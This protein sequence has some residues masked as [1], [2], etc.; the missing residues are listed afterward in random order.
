[1]ENA[2]IYSQRLI[3]IKLFYCDADIVADLIIPTGNSANS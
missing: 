1:M 3:D 2:L